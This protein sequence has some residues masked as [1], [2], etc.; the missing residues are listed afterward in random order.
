MIL[1]IL[2]QFLPCIIFRVYSVVARAAKSFRK[3]KLVVTH[4][5]KRKSTR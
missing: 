1:K 4:K 2:R 5:K 3:K